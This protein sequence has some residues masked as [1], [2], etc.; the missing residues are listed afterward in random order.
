MA[1]AG[2]GGATV[3]PSPGGVAGDGGDGNGGDDDSDVTW[4]TYTTRQQTPSRIGVVMLQETEV[5]E[6]R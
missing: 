6:K 5:V 3:T 2:D 4:T 1:M